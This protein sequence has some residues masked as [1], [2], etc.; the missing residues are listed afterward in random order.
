[1]QDV[2]AFFE[3]VAIV[4]IVG[5]SVPISQHHGV[6]VHGTRMGLSIPRIH[7]WLGAL[8][9]SPFS[10]LFFSFGSAEN[11][12]GHMSSQRGTVFGRITV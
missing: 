9:C 7:C 10:R 4:G 6:D 11:R 1:M 8:C 2:N 12:G 3:A 5:I